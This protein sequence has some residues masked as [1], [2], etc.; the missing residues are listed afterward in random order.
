MTLRQVE[1]M[2]DT[3]GSVEIESSQGK[4]RLTINGGGE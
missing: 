4:H 3:Y 1:R 2:A